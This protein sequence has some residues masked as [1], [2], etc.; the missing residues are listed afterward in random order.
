M[1]NKRGQVTAFVIV[2]IVIVLGV[3]VYF[4]YK[5]N[6]SPGNIS[7]EFQPIFSYY[8]SC[9]EKETKT[10]VEIAGTQGGKIFVEDYVAGSSYAPFSSE[11]NFL[12]VSVP[13]WYYLTGNGLI[14]ENVPTKKDIENEIVRYVSENIGECDFSDF[15]EQGYDI[16]FGNEDVKVVVNE[17]KVDVSVKSDI[18]VSKGESSAIKNV[19]EVSVNSRLGEFY[20]SAKKVYELE[21]QNSF[22]EDYA[23][24]VLRLYAPVDG[25][26]ISCSGKIWKTR[27]VVNDLKEGL[28]ANIQ[29][30]TFN[31]N[32]KDKNK[33]YVVDLDVKNNVEFSYLNNWPSVVEISGADD[34]LMIAESV[35]TQ[36]GLTSLG[37]CYAPYHFVYDIKFPVMIRVRE[38]S[39]IFQFPVVVIIDKNL[40]R[41]GIY[42]SE[43]AGEEAEFD[44]CEFKT[45]D[46]EINVYDVNLD[47][48]D[49]STIYYDCFDQRC[50]LGESANGKFVGKAPNCVNG[51]LDVRTEGYAQGK[52]LYSTNQNNSI[53]VVLD[54][55]KEIFVEV[56]V[57]GNDLDGNAIISLNNGEKSYTTALPEV[58]KILLSEGLY[59]VSVY[60]YG[61]SSIKIPASVKTQC[62][63]VPEKGIGGFFGRTKETC[64]NIEV[65]ETIID[66]ALVGGGNSEIYIFDSDLNSERMIIKVGGLTRPTS[67]E[68]LQANYAEFEISDVEVEFR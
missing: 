55:E 13:Y 45:Q 35:G 43:I 7:T 5:N 1:E 11:L 68:D 25:S 34:E 60:V 4:A 46:V 58:D 63:D 2:A 9:L 16:N 57:D 52:V 23:I 27:E 22:L 30:I 32:L 50:L 18:S 28:S 29:Q 66:S 54:R 65:P 53:D 49:N 19:Y 67:I 59:N 48:I 61:N 36:Q 33:Y 37:F 20:N 17:N 24:D 64:F 14:E 56:K 47:K 31:K 3:V 62:Q 8:S 6:F 51:F 12:G 41:K 38:G 39:E 40:P 15:Y 21:K 10:A 26:E 44:L 42:S